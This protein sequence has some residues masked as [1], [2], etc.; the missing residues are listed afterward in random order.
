MLYFL[1]KHKKLKIEMKLERIEEE[2][3]GGRSRKRKTSKE[4]YLFQPV[5]ES[6][7]WPV[8]ARSVKEREEEAVKW[9]F[10]L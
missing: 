2:Y 6:G 4:N 5:T 9:I 10:R 8:V 1:S 7:Q 3:I